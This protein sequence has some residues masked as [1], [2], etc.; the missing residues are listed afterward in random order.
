ME[1]ASKNMEDTTTSTDRCG[2]RLCQN[3]DVESEQE[4]AG[5]HGK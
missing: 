2:P 1:S 5:A 4:N 3:K